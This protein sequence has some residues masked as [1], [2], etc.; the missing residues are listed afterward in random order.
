M[1]ELPPWVRDADQSPPPP[2]EAVP[3]QAGRPAVSPV[4]ESA[5]PL[6]GGGAPPV[7]NFPP[8]VEAGGDRAVSAAAPPAMDAR[9]IAN[10]EPPRTSGYAQVQGDAGPITPADWATLTPPKEALPTPPGGA[11]ATTQSPEPAKTQAT[12]PPKQPAPE[13]RLATAP[14][15]A[16]LPQPEVASAPFKGTIPMAGYN[17]VANRHPEV[18]NTIAQVGQSL[19]VTTERLIQHARME[20]DLD[21]NKVG[22]LGE[23]GPF[24]I[25]PSTQADLQNRYLGGR[26][27]DARTWEGGALLAALKIRECDRRGA[28]SYASVACYAGGGD[29][30]KR[31]AAE[32]F[33]DKKSSDYSKLNFG[34]LDKPNGGSTMTA[35]GVVQAFRAGP[36][37]GMKYLVDTSS[38]GSSM[39]DAW[40][41][42]QS[43]LV[44]HFILKG[45]MDGAEKAQDFIMRQAF[46]G[47]NMHLMG[48]AAS[49]ERGDG[50]TAAQQLA[51][52]HAFF[53][54]GTAG[55]FMTNG[56]DVFGVRLDE[57]TGKPLGSP[58]KITAQDVRAQLHVTTNP[59]TFTKFLSDQQKAAAEIRLHNAQAGYQEV[60]PAIEEMKEVGRAG[61]FAEGQAG[62][63]ARQ[64]LVQQ[65]IDRRQAMALAAGEAKALREKSP[66]T[67]AQLDKFIS[68]GIADWP[69]DKNFA[70]TPREAEYLANREQTLRSLK[71]NAP[72]G[73]IGLGVAKRIADQLLT[74][75]FTLDPQA[76]GTYNIIDAKTRQLIPGSP[77]LDT[78][79]GELLTLKTHPSRR[80]QQQQQQQGA[81]PSGT[82]AG[83][84]ADFAKR[85][86]AF[87]TPQEAAKNLTSV[88]APG[89]AAF[90]V[91]RLAAPQVQ[92]FVNDLEGL[93]YK[94]NP[95]T[96][97]AYN[98]RNKKGVDSVEKSE[99][100]YG[101]AFDI[102]WDRNKQADTLITDLP[103][104]V[105]DI[106]AKWGLKWGGDFR[107]KK[108]AMH[109][110]VA[111][112]LG[113]QLAA[114]ASR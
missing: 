1:S 49:L 79:T 28:D 81:A 60:R 62:M 50:A 18:F 76:N 112:L 10:E 4:Q 68:E 85:S 98:D 12:P 14:G 95:T 13:D 65:Y 90:T 88:S 67:A 21:P 6:S 16:A 37:T 58:F 73:N 40:Q 5:L 31:Y 113:S 43:A 38:R 56:R 61:R 55:R 54:D 94:I 11:V 105:S 66:E 97:G 70:G 82:G 46:M 36:D 102:N 15:A 51:K 41:Q 52:A 29:P 114:R 89:G 101:S 42:A 63:A 24:Q 23:L 25:L 80:Q 92:G 44:E 30:S 109:F 104:N 8:P 100:A 35:N 110:E 69:V 22:D 77:P 57:A 84:E 26:Q 39:T 78:T 64:G 91:H 33:S 72:G 47:S 20:S 106:A 32:Y 3:G 53:P 87:G 45:D 59:M 27:V 2:P 99:H 83:L 103:R 96:S 111:H 19:G 9:A 17:W 74:G 71:L 108:D 75:A 7:V 48:A 34:D 93:G 86:G 107:G